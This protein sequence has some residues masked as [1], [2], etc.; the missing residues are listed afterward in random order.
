MDT[1]LFS[2]PSG[3]SL[4]LFPVFC[5]NENRCSRHPCTYVFTFWCFYFHGLAGPEGSCIFHLSNCCQ[6][7]LLKMLSP[8][9]C[10]PVP[11]AW[12]TRHS[13]Q[14]PREHGYGEIGRRGAQRRASPRARLLL[15]VVVVD[16]V[17][18]HHVCGVD[19]LALD[20]QKLSIW[21]T[22][23]WRLVT[24]PMEKTAVPYFT[25]PWT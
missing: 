13:T 20:G 4:T 7:S 14:P 18:N 8:F 12:M 6:I 1:H 5:Y 2:H 10:P 11:G 17:E 3:G 16:Q 24:H 15:P 25:A 23:G 22:L 21:R 9:R 19:K